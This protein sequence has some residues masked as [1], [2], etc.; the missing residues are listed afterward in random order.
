MNG[1]GRSS[2]RDGDKKHEP[3]KADAWLP[4]L[5]YLVHG[6]HRDLP[7]LY[8]MLQQ[9][10]TA[11]AAAGRDPETLTYACNVAVLV[12]E[13]TP[14]RPGLIAGGPAE[15]AGAPAVLVSHGFTFL[16]FFLNG[17]GTEQRERLA[18]EVVP[19][20]RNQVAILAER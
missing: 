12:Q 16:N 20:V 18:W 17:D 11:A 1:Q 19:E 6:M 14:P 15:V 4:T 13:G 9:V 3:S 7:S 10:R 2:P 5:P 8:G